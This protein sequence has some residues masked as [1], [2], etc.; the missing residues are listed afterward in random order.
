MSHAVQLLLAI[1]RGIR[2][3]QCARRPNRGQLPNL[4]EARKMMYLAEL[5]ILGVVLAGMAGH[6]VLSH[7]VLL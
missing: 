6:A 2:P 3:G 5:L 7:G 4:A 1:T